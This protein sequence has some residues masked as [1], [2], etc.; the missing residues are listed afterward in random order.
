MADPALVELHLAMTGAPVPET[1]KLAQDLG[2]LNRVHALGLVLES[3]LPAH[4]RGAVAVAMPSLYEGFGLPV[5][6]AM[7]CGVPAV[8][9]GVTA[10]PEVAGNGAILVVPTDLDAVVD[11]LRVAVYDSYSRTRL[12][13]A[14]PAQ[15]AKFTWD[16]AGH[17]AEGALRQVL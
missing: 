17:H 5:L 2:I 3:Q 6:E 7:A 13:V 1:M 12:K 8:A 10:V 11:G 9:G 15:A 16:T 4:Y 14:G